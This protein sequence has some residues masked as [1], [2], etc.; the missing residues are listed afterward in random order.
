MH[1]IQPKGMEYQYDA[2][3]RTKMYDESIRYTVPHR[4]VWWINTM[5]DT[6]QKG[7][8]NQ[9]DAS[10]YIARH[11]NSTR[12]KVSYDANKTVK[13]MINTCDTKYHTERLINH[14]IKNTTG[15]GMINQ[16]SSRYH[17]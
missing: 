3:Y 4:N 13:G 2:Q 8:V 12:R 14:R 17:T 6:T 9:Y 5:Y 10:T 1:N 11:D 16:Q 15:K 7:M